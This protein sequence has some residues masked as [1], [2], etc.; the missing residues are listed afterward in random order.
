MNIM[1]GNHY[2]SGYERVPVP[3]LPPIDPFSPSNVLADFLPPEANDVL[4]LGQDI[5]TQPL[6]EYDLENFKYLMD[7]TDD[8]DS[9]YE[10]PLY[11][12]FDIIFDRTVS[13]LFNG[14]IDR[15]FEVYATN[16]YLNKAWIHYKK[17]TQL[18]FKIFNGIGPQKYQVTNV[19]FMP[20]SPVMN[21][22]EIKRNKVWYINSI[23]GLDKL[24]AKIPK[25]TE[26]KLTITLSEDVAMLVN[27]MIDSYNNFAYNYAQQ[28]YN[29]PD[30][31]MRFKMMIRFSDMRTMKLLNHFESPDYMYD[32]ASEIYTLYDCNFD[33]FNSKNFGDEVING[34]F[35]V[36]KQDNPS[37]VKFDIIYKSIQK[38][39]RTPLIKGERNNVVNNKEV[40]SNLS[41]T[42]LFRD[43]LGRTLE[44]E[45]SMQD[46][47]TGAFG[48]ATSLNNMLQNYIPKFQPPFPKL[49]PDLLGAV[50]D[51]TNNENEFYGRRGSIGE[52]GNSPVDELVNGDLPNVDPLL[53]RK[54][55][56]AK[57]TLDMK[58]NFN[59]VLPSGIA[60]L[61]LGNDYQQITTAPRQPHLDFDYHNDGTPTHGDLG[62]I[63]LFLRPPH[64]GSLGFDYTNIGFTFGGNLGFDYTN[65][66]SPIHGDLG[67]DYT[68]DG[69][70]IH[71]DLGFDYTNNGSPI[72]GDLGFDY[73][74]DG[75]P[76][77][78]NLGNDYA[79]IGSRIP[80]TNITLFGK[81]NRTSPSLGFLYT[82]LSELR[83]VNLNSLYDNSVQR[84][85]VPLGDLY[86]N[87]SVKNTNDLGTDFS[88][89][90][91]KPVPELNQLFGKVEKPP[92]ELNSLFTNNENQKS[93]QDM[94]TLFSG[95]EKPSVQDLGND[96]ANNGIRPNTDLGSDFTN[97]D[98]KRNVS[99]DN[100]YDNNSIGHNQTDLNSLYNNVIPPKQGL[101]G[102]TID[103]KTTEKSKQDLGESYENNL[104]E[105]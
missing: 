27:Y 30:N 18:F 34:G 63:S 66:G 21:S 98:Q 43:K 44:E 104:I 28:R 61:N 95:T 88:N 89:V 42:N 40:D 56:I 67:F 96:F 68:N 70:P 47:L 79:N 25:Y 26:D 87:L 75:I 39:F 11:M 80:L 17:F 101:E 50:Y 33:F 84:T 91:G 102:D 19:P 99:L 58:D 97:T 15:F 54:N 46:I 16:D 103:I 10:D 90:A 48:A 53:A 65:D 86:S 31:L 49:P 2:I 94:G 105:E 74:N 7:R 29:L 55:L 37:T 100:V 14:E 57:F 36:A 69:S 52:T 6:V 35:G 12:S 92:V 23:L 60:G 51:N 45:I 85:Y 41:L 59:R 77:H 72:H 83:T 64:T 38:E 93:T 81:G 82:N 4:G 5:H 32:K 1:R 13:P 76:T 71:G 9:F 62:F 8:A 3:P 73:T 78:G 22:A 24:T 20:I